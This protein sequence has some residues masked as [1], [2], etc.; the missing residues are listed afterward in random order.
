[1]IPPYSS[2]DTGVSATLVMRGT[3]P[4]QVYYRVQ[5]D[6]ESPRQLSKTFASSRGELTLQ[7]ERSGHYIFTFVQ[8]SDTYYKKV[9][10]N[11]PSIEQ[12]VHPLAAADFVTDY[13]GNKRTMSS[14]EGGTVGVDVDLRVSCSTIVFE[15]TDVL[16]NQGT[17]PWNLEVQ[18]V[19][20]KSSE[21]IHIKGIETPRKTL[22]VPVPK[23]VDTNGGTFEINIGEC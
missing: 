3:P 2:G 20:P 19:G 9:Q 6:S 21:N 5:R 1:M 22:Q 16:L 7:P 14:C 4:F 17:G 18:V 10:L 8:M 23:M 11:G 15:P 13:N 12:V